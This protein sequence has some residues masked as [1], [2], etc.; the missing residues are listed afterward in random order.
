MV[1]SSLNPWFQTR[2]N[3]GYWRKDFS[4]DFEV[5]QKKRFLLF[6]VNIKNSEHRIPKR[7][8]NDFP[9]RSI[10]HRA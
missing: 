5:N 2:G 8:K 1:E 10:V 6:K 4:G 7:G 9:H 3:G